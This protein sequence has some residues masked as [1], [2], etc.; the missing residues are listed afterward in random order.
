M[1]YNEI[2]K[3]IPKLKELYSTFTDWNI[4]K[5]KMC[6][7]ASN[8]KLLPSLIEL[9]DRIVNEYT[10]IP[11]N[12]KLMLEKVRKMLLKLMSYTAVAMVLKNLVSLIS[13]PKEVISAIN[14]FINIDNSILE[15]LKTSGISIC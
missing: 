9:I 7:W 3:Y 6:T 14:V 2:K 1:Y 13:P 5:S 10:N 4:L 15:L 12:T 11:Q 8:N